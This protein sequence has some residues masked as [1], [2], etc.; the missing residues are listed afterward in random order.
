MD[1]MSKDSVYYRV[2]TTKSF[3]DNTIG[4]VIVVA[5]DVQSYNSR[6]AV[7]RINKGTTRILYKGVVDVCNFSKFE[8][9]VKVFSSLFTILHDGSTGNFS[10]SCPLKKGV[11][12]MNN[13]R[14]PDNS[15]VLR[16]L[17]APNS[18]YTM[19]GLNSWVFPNG[20]KFL[21]HDFNITLTIVKK[22]H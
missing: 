11:Y 9:N 21:M 12:V 7:S 8:K 3:K 6:V 5:Q 14:I 20:S 19:S 2:N 10:M 22:C 13:I 15:P 4:A 1:F 17:Y 18:K 16:F